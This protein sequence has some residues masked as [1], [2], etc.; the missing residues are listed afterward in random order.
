MYVRLVGDIHQEK[1]LRTAWNV[2]ANEIMARVRVGIDRAFE[3]DLTFKHKLQL[4][5]LTTLP[6]QIRLLVSATNMA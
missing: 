4:G 2:S 3:K 1:R 5:M 6:M